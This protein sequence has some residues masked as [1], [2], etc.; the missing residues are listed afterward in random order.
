[1]A[2]VE[3]P[4][5]DRF[6]RRTTALATLSEAD[7]EPLADAWQDTLYEDH[8]LCTLRGEAKDGTPFPKTTYRGS[9]V[10]PKA[11]ARS[12]ARFGAKV[13][14]FG[15]FGP[16]A[17]G[18]HNNLSPAEYRKLDGPP[19]APRGE[20]SRILTNWFSDWGMTGPGQMQVASFLMDI[21]D[22]KGRPFMTSAHFDGGSGKVRD[23]RGISAWGVKRAEKQLRDYTEALLSRG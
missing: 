12:G 6:R 17:S 9:S 18:L 8:R 19:L 11:R 21:V 22:I 10:R 4:D 23:A 2:T 1:M 13:G 3:W 14:D 16:F 7:L 15:G 20:H 5:F